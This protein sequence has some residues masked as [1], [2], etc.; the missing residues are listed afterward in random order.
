M[1]IWFYSYSS[2]GFK[3]NLDCAEGKRARPFRHQNEKGEL[4][5]AADVQGLSVTANS[6]SIDALDRAI[7]DYYAWKGDPVGLLM[8]AADA[9]PKFSLGYSASASLLLLSGF[10]RSNPMVAEALQGAERTVSE[11][12]PR[13]RKHLEAAKAWA[14]GE[15]IRATTIW[16][17]ILLDH[18]RDALALRFCHDTYFYLGA[19]QT[20]RD[21]VARVLP[22]WSHSDPAY[23]YVLGQ[24]AF[25]LEECSE[26]RHAEKVAYQAIEIN[27]ED[28]WAVHALAHVMETES[29]QE[30][31]IRFL[32]N[33]QPAWRKAHALAAHNGWHLA[34]YLIEQQR[35]DEVLASYDKFV[36]PKINSDAILDLV[37]AASLLWR[38]ELAGGSVGN[39]WR[40]IS[41]QWMH[42]VDEHV[43]AFNDLHIAFCAARSDDA[44]DATRLRASLDR[45][46]REGT[47]DNHRITRS[48]GRE[49]IEA[50]L[51]F[52]E[53]NYGRCVDLILPLRY[54]A[55]RVGGSHAQRDIIGQTLIVAAERAGRMTLA[56]ALLNER[57]AQRPT[58][59]TEQHLAHVVKAV[60]AGHNLSALNML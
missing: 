15:M 46:D 49:I 37:D 22:H 2:F 13:E 29:R 10:T 6:H 8:G 54:D 20:I 56:R 17:D 7:S 47:G 53:G 31:G 30:D 38:I 18:P 24:Y 1:T 14:A 57:L 41:R 33:S 21:S 3:L 44:D 23:G 42:H 39:R 55:I 9:D 58:S 60:T 52:G 32:R 36:Q 25:G 4:V 19:S 48:I 34:L 59:A 51:A 27:E 35:F 5:M 26:L 11:A 28:G 43:L 40:D 45:Y 50:M 12:N 16:E